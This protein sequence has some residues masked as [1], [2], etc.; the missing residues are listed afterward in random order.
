MGPSAPASS[1]RS[2][3]GAG[4][5]ALEAIRTAAGGVRGRG[6]C[7]HPDGT[8]WFALS[9][10]DTFTE[11]IAAH[12]TRDG[13]GQQVKGVLPLP[14]GESAVGSR[15]AVDW[16]RCD[17]HGLCAHLVPELIQ[18]DGNGYRSF[19]DTP[20]PAWLEPGAKRAVGACPALALR[21]SGKPGVPRRAARR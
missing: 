6:A 18:L 19:P 15:L 11:D 12:L 4:G 13:C 2:A 10:L 3:R 17:G 8:A 1:C 5:N 20:V 9:A 7:S 16:A 14:P 21:L